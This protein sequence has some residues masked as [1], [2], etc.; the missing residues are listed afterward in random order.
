MGFFGEATKQ[1]GPQARYEDPSLRKHNG[2]ATPG[3]MHI[4]YQ[5]G[6]LQEEEN[7]FHCKDHDITVDQTGALQYIQILHDDMS[8]QIIRSS[9]LNIRFFPD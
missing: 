2:P 9:Y 7:R 3:T 4:S 1:Y 6:S 8:V 5:N